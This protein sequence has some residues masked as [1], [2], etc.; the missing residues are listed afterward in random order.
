MVDIQSI[1]IS[2]GTRIR[3]NQCPSGLPGLGHIT[4]YSNVLVPIVTIRPHCYNH[5]TRPVFDC[6]RVRVSQTHSSFSLVRLNVQKVHNVLNLSIG[7]PRSV[8]ACA[9]PALGR[10]TAK[11]MKTGLLMTYPTI[12]TCISFS[13]IRI[14]KYVASLTMIQFANNLNCEL[15]LLTNNLCTIQPTLSS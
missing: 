12:H 3:E 8:C 2:I 11:L 13:L 14:F 10:T 7:T 4:A 9:Q 6:A 1:C 15:Y 5:E